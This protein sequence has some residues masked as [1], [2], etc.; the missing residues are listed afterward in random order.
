MTTRYEIHLDGVHASDLSLA[1]LRDLIDFVIEGAGRAARLAAEGRSTARGAAP[2]WL[3]ASGD[4]HL[5]G[6]REGSL[7][8]DLTARPLGEIAADVF[9]PI[10]SDTAFDLL[11]EAIDDALRGRRDSDRLDLGILQVL[12]KTRGLFGRGPSLLRITSPDGRRIELSDA[13]IEKFQRLATEPP[14]TQVDRLVGILDSLTVSS[15]TCLLRMADGMPLKGYL[16]A[17]ANLDDWKPLLGR[18]VVVEGAVAFRPSGRP[19]RIDIDHIAPATAR[20]AV[21][22]RAPRGELA[23]EQLSLS[24]GDLAT[25]FGQWPGDED[26][27]QVL[28][29]LRELS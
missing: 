21:W 4:V 9:G 12:V 29:A 19:Q 3:A 8:L 27:D 18:E 2:I 16:G 15:R 11:L 28:L 25:Y 7:A 24:T 22:K 5:V 26:D 14:P 17:Q 6:I 20:D 1:V 10:A 13:S 23:H